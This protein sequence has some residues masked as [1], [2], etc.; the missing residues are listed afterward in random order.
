MKKHADKNKNL[1]GPAD[2]FKTNEKFMFE[3][4]LAERKLVE[5]RRN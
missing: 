5:N 4:F 2:Y 3:L 1:I